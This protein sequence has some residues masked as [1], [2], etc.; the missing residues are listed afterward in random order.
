[1]ALPG[2]VVLTLADIAAQLGGDVLGDSQTQVSRVAPVADGY[3]GGDYVP[4]EPEIQKPIEAPARLRRLFFAR[5]WSVN[6][7]ARVSLP[8]IPTHTMPG[9]RRY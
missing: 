8:A 6:F 5:M 3:G 7:P 9:S 2:K 4:G 1:M